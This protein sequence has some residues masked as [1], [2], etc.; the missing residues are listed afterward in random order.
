MIPKILFLISVF[1]LPCAQAA[2]TFSEY[3]VFPLRDVKNLDG[4]WQFA[5]LGPIPDVISFNPSSTITDKITVVPSS[6]DLLPYPKNSLVGQ[7]GAVLYR[8]TVYTTPN[9][10][11]RIRIGACGF[12]CSV[13]VDGDLV[14]SHGGNGY[15]AFWIGGIPP[16][17]KKTRTLEIIADNRF[18]YTTAILH[19]YVEDLF[20]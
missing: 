19:G 16:S 5:W 1:A 11:A 2:G 9:T 6:F 7:R 14:G 12:F 3:P 18:N 4:I 8:T 13:W 15:T 10:F 20:Q 17:E